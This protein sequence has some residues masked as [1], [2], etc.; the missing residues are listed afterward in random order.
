MLSYQDLVYR[1]GLVLRPGANTENVFFKLD[2]SNMD[3]TFTR[4][5]NAMAENELKHKTDTG[6]TLT[7]A[8]PVKLY[9]NENGLSTL[10]SQS[11]SRYVEP[12]SNVRT[13][14][15]TYLSTIGITQFDDDGNEIWGT[16]L[17]CSQ[18]YKSYH[19]YYDPKALSKKWQEQFIL[20]DLPEQAY[21]RQFFSVNTYTSGRDLF[22]VYN[23]DNK[24]FNNSI[25]HPGDTIYDFSKAN[26]C[27]YKVDRKREV[28][29]KYLF[30][31]P[32]KNEYRSSFIEGAD[33]DEQRGIYAALIQYRKNDETSL[34]MAWAHL[35]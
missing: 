7:D 24:N 3:V 9:T 16:V 6:R 2:E 10:V 30:G 4:L 35:D 15:I 18:Y 17:P 27:Y 20:S 22:I 34:Q 25:A 19:H 29:K 5:R 23:D 8:L 21:Y 1:Y 26:A 13:N 11:Y 14:F 12:E 33:Y 28:T 31:D 32:A